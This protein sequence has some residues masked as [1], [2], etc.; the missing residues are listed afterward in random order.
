MKPKVIDLFAGVGG[1]S[2]GFKMAGFEIVLANEFEESI[3]K[4][5]IYNHPDT[6]VVLSQEIGEAKLV[7]MNLSKVNSLTSCNSI[8]SSISSK[9]LAS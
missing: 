4:S 2:L 3:A 8:S 6:E 1:L 7:L 9:Y 5:Y